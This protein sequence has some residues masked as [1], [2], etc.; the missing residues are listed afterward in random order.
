MTGEVNLFPFTDRSRP[1]KGAVIFIGLFLTL[2]TDLVLM[3][4][5]LIGFGVLY[6]DITLLLFPLFIFICIWKFIWL[7]GMMAELIGV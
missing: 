7:F 3:T 2:I 6:G 1:Q 5:L 4:Y